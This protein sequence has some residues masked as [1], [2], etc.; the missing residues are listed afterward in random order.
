[1][2]NFEEL[3]FDVRR[4]KPKKGQIMAKFSAVAAFGPGQEKKDVISLLKIDKA[5]QAS[6]VMNGI[7]CARVP[8]CYRVC[9]EMAEDLVSGLS[10]EEVENKEY[11]YVLEAFY[12]TERENVPDTQHWSTIPVIKYDPENES[13]KVNIEM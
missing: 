5:Y 10:D 12:Y 13:F 9:R 2:D 6:Q 1:M 11:E 3:F 7:H 8:D 4:H